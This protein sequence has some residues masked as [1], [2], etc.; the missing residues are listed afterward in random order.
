MTAGNGG[1][2]RH[3]SKWTDED[4]VRLEELWGTMRDA[5]VA[6][7]LGKTVST[8]RFKAGQLSLREKKGRRAGCRPGR[9]TYPWSNEEDLVLKKNVGYMNIFELQDALPRRNRV[10][11]ERR[12]YELGF[13]PTQGTYTRARIEKD[14]GYD[15]R[16]IR[17]AKEAL[18]QTWKRYGE[19]KY[20]ISFDQVQEIVEWLRD[21][22]RKWSREYNLDHCVDCGADGEDDTERH[23]G[24]GL[25]KQCW[26]DRRHKRARVHRA[27]RDG[28]YVHLTKEVW[29]EHACD[30]PP[31]SAEIA[32]LIA[33]CE[34]SAQPD[35]VS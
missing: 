4:V 28:F 18:G 24:D 11:I 17:R 2:G 12:C 26:D 30:E 16:Q 6:E 8:V 9:V 10:A 29:L 32:A 22:T 34:L 5:D 21:E 23:S 13:S 33:Q 1:L 27:F 14:T 35:Q 3:K 15:W 7:A 19:R 31:D 25:C 20:M